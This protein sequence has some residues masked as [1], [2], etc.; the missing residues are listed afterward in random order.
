[1]NCQDL[2][3]SNI[4]LINY[5]NKLSINMNATST[6]K[7]HPKI[8]IADRKIKQIRKD[9]FNSNHGRSELAKSS[10]TEASSEKHKL[11]L[12]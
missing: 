2:L 5:N 6:N 9:K 8:G 7:A 10:K 12:R 3:N 4:K 1:M 11:R